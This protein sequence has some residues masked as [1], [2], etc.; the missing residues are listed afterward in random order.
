[1]TNARTVPCRR[2]ASASSGYLTSGLRVERGRPA[3]SRRETRSP[4]GRH[5]PDGGCVTRSVGEQPHVHG[6]ERNDARGRRRRGRGRRRGR[7]VAGG[8]WRLGAACVGRRARLREQGRLLRGHRDGEGR[9]TAQRREAARAGADEQD[10]QRIATRNLRAIAHRDPRD[11]RE[12]QHRVHGQRRREGAAPGR[13]HRR[14]RRARREHGGRVSAWP[15]KTGSACSA[16]LF[17]RTVPGGLAEG[18]PSVRTHS[19]SIR[20]V[21][22][23]PPPNAFG[24]TVIGSIDALVSLVNDDREFRERA[25]RCRARPVRGRPRLREK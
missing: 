11:Q 7:R 19:P 24:F 10:G 17:P 5:A 9:R 25:C 16:A 3:R 13:R 15:R 8:R 18:P 21:R 1:M 4:R 6:A 20:H 12:Q 23:W 2:A 14:P 22:R